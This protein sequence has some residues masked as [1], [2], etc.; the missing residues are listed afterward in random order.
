MRLIVDLRNPVAIWTVGEA[1][2][3]VIRAVP[4]WEVRHVTDDAD[5]A[6]ALAEGADA[7]WCWRCDAADAARCPGLRWVATPAAGADY[8]DAAGLLDAGIRV[9]VSHGHH[10]PAIAEHVLGMVLSL[11]RRLHRAREWAAAGG[12]WR[13]ETDGAAMI[14]LLHADAAIVGYG[15]IGRAIGER[16]RAFGCR[17]RGLRRAAVSGETDELGVQLVGPGGW[18]EALAASRVVVNVL[19][20]TPATS[21]W[22]DRRRLCLLPDPCIL[23]NVGRGETVDERAL[24]DLARTRDLRLGLDVFAEEPLPADHPLRDLPE[25]LL[26]PHASAMTPTYLHRAAEAQAEQMRRFA[27]GEE[28]HWPVDPDDPIERPRIL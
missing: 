24:V 14:D 27:A 1:E 9:T 25:A 18:D 16:L 13:D 19:P 15:A 21:G 8:L 28:L 22:F 10:G 4:G 12:W 5:R 20:H 17:V 3:S 23:V 6:A 7:L 26:T 2:L 11:A